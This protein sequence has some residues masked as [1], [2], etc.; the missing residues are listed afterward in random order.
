MIE[1][2]VTSLEVSKRLDKVLKE[3]G[4]EAP[5]SPLWWYEGCYGGETIPAYLLSELMAVMPSEIKIKSTRYKIALIYSVYGWSIGLLDIAK[6]SDTCQYW[7]RDFDSYHSGNIATAAGE[8][9]IY[10]IENKL[11]GG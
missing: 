8:L 4:I 7:G 3:K 11:W 2:H 6:S 1:N 9:C 5:E 10:L